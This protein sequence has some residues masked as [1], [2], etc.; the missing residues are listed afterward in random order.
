MLPRDRVVKVPGK[1]V[2]VSPVVAPGDELPV[3]AEID[4]PMEDGRPLV[5]AGLK[6]KMTVH[7]NELA[8]PRCVP[9]RPRE[10]ADQG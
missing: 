6:A 10:E 1:I 7:V 2:F 8:S 5:R 3:W 9:L 4:T